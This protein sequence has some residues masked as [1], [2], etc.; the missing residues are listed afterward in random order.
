MSHPGIERLLARLEGSEPDHEPQRFR[1]GAGLI[2]GHDERLRHLFPTHPTAAAVLVG[3]V[4]RELEPTILLTVRAAALRTHAGQI[5]FPGGRVEPTDA[6]PAA[7]ALR[8]AREEIGLEAS[9]VRVVGYLPD[10]LVLTG[11]RVTPVVA[12]LTPGFD[13]KL[14]QSEVQDV[15]EMPWSHLFDEGNYRDYRR[16]FAGTEIDVRDIS[17]GPHNI[18][19]ATAGILLALREL[20]GEGPAMGKRQ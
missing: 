1:V 2:R 12:R 18:W 7:A 6:G 14:D 8:E 19:G 17:Y 16:N 13:L 11:Y 20:A 10:H 9:R 5:A 3:L 4:D 15:F